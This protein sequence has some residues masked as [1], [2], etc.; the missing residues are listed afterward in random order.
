MSATITDLLARQVWDSRG[1]PTIEV[2]VVLV[3]GVR[4]RAIAP[5]GASTGKR[6]ALDRRDGGRRLGGYGVDGPLADLRTIV[7]PL[8][9]GRDAND[10]QG[11]DAALREADGTPQKSRLGGNAIVAASTAVAWAAAAQSGRPL[12]QHLSGLSGIAP[13]IPLP[14]I[15]IFG[16]GRHAAQR[17]DVQDYLVLCVGASS[18]AEAMEWTA[19]IYMAAASRMAARSGAGGVADEGGI[20]PAFARN[21]DGFAQI[22]EAIAAAGLTTDQV[23]IA[24]DVA[25]SSFAVPGGYK[26]GLE[27][28]TLTTDEL[29]DRVEGW[30]RNFPIIS[31]EDP[32]GEDD[33]EGFIEI[34][35]RIGD[36][37]QIVGDDY[38]VTDAVAIT[39]AA[40]QRAGNAALLKINQCGT[41]S[42]LIGA[43][44]AARA[45]GWH[46]V[47]SGR[48]GE[49][50]D[51]TLAHLAVGLG[52]DQMKVGS[53]TR[54]ERTAKWNEMLRIEETAALPFKF[55]AKP[56]PGRRI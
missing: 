43:A 17:V 52:S 13:S 23:G 44:R 18:F 28:R 19:E 53:M 16:G 9:I 2:E 45:S 50:E 11:I 32:V 31:V 34:T 30:V 54:S 37:V 40:R 21:E 24:V 41:L 20:W 47:Q 7:R 29:V 35:R 5:S 27:G 6:E 25:A 14:M 39:E 51:V 56:L 26:L 8:L 55:A 15:Q 33:T 46:A 4:G 3:S 49:S 48:S 42:E 38:L 10:Q 12:W 22:V 1:R 36:R